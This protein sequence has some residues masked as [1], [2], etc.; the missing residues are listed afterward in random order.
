MP[1]PT[2]LWSGVKKGYAGGRKPAVAWEGSVIHDGQSMGKTS[3]AF[4]ENNDLLHP[5]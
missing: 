2:I 4:S 5:L 1:G 3:I